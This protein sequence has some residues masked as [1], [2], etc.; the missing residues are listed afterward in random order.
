MSAIDSDSSPMMGSLSEMS[1]MSRSRHSAMSMPMPAAKNAPKTFRGRPESLGQFMRQY[2][3]LALLHELSEREKCEAVVDYCSTRVKETIEGL[4][5][6]Q[7]GHWDELKADIERVFDVESVVKKFNL[8]HLV[9]LCRRFSSG[10]EGAMKSMKQ[11][12]FYVQSFIRIAGSLQA[13]ERISDDDFATY[14]WMG[15]PPAFREKLETRIRNKLPDHDISRPF[16]VDVIQASAEELLHRDRFD[17]QRV[18]W[19]P[20][21]DD[22]DESDDES[23]YYDDSDDED[24]QMRFNKSFKKQEKTGHSKGRISPEL[25]PGLLRLPPKTKETSIMRSSP[26]RSKT[27]PAQDDDVSSLIE[28]MNKLSVTDKAYGLLYYRAKRI[29][30]GVVGCVPPPRL[31]VDVPTRPPQENAYRTETAYRPENSF[32]SDNAYRSNVAYA[33][34]RRR[35]PTSDRYSDHFSGCYG[36]GQRGHNF[37][38]C[39]RIL[40]M[41]ESGVIQR[42]PQGVL[43]TSDGQR[44]YRDSDE[45]FIQALEKIPMKS[46]FI[47]LEEDFTEDSEP[48]SSAVWAAQFTPR[49]PA[50]KPS[51]RPVF[52][53]VQMP[54]RPRPPFQKPAQSRGSTHPTPVDAIPSRFD[55]TKDDIVMEDIAMRPPP[56]K[57]NPLPS[58]ETHDKG[59][60]APRAAARHSALSDK[61]SPARVIEQALDTPVTLTIGQLLG[62]SRELTQNLAELLRFKKPVES[63]AITTNSVPAR[64]TAPLLRLNMMCNGTAVSFVIDSGS[65]VNLLSQDI[66]HKIGLPVD[67]RPSVAIKDANGGLGRAVGMIPN[68]TVSCGHIQTRTNFFIAKGIPFD[69]LLGRPWQSD[70]LVSIKEDLKGTFLEFPNADGKTISKVL[71]NQRISPPLREDDSDVESDLGYVMSALLADEHQGESR[72]RSLPGL[73]LAEISMDT[74]HQDISTKHI[75]KKPRLDDPLLMVTC[76]EKPVIA[77]VDAASPISLISREVWDMAKSPGR[78]MNGEVIDSKHGLTHELLAKITDLP[79]IVDIEGQGVTTVTDAFVTTD[80]SVPLLLGSPWLEHNFLRTSLQ[81]DTFRVTQEKIGQIGTEPSRL[82]VTGQTASMAHLRLVDQPFIA[83]LDQTQLLNTMGRRAQQELGLTMF[84]RTESTAGYQILGVVEGLSFFYGH[85]AMCSVPATF[86]ILDSYDSPITL[87]KPWFTDNHIHAPKHR[88]SEYI[89]LPPDL[90]LPPPHSPVPTEIV[91]TSSIQISESGRE[92]SQGPRMVTVKQEEDAEEGDSEPDD[93][94]GDSSDCCSSCD[95]ERRLLRQRPRR[96]SRRRSTPGPIKIRVRCN[97]ESRETV[98][99]PKG[100]SNIMSKAVWKQV[101]CPLTS[102]PIRTLWTGPT[103]CYDVFGIAK[104]VVIS[105][106]F[107]RRDVF[108]TF[109]VVEQDTPG[110]S[111]GGQWLM[112][113]DITLPPNPSQEQV[114]LVLSHDPARFVGKTRE[115]APSP[116]LTRR[117]SGTSEVSQE[118]TPMDTAPGSP[119]TEECTPLETCSHPPVTV[120]YPDHERILDFYSRDLRHVRESATMLRMSMIKGKPKGKIS[121]SAM[122]G[123]DVGSTSVAGIFGKKY[124]LPECTMQSSANDWEWIGPAIVQLFPP[125]D[126]LDR[127]ARHVANLRRRASEPVPPKVFMSSAVPQSPRASDHSIPCPPVEVRYPRYLP[128]LHRPAFTRISTRRPMMTLPG[129]ICGRVIPF[130][131]DTASEVNILHKDVWKYAT[132]FHPETA[133]R[134][135]PISELTEVPAICDYGGR[136]H[137]AIGIAY[138][139]VVQFGHIATLANFYII[140]GTVPTAVLGQPWHYDHPTSTQSGLLGIWFKLSIP[141]EPRS[142]EAFFP[143]EDPTRKSVVDIPTVYV[144]SVSAQDIDRSP[145]EDITDKL[146]NMSVNL[147]APDPP[148]LEKLSVDFVEL[149]AEHG[150]E[151]AKQ[152]PESILREIAERSALRVH[153]DKPSSPVE[154]SSAEISGKLREDLREFQMWLDI[155]SMDLYMARHL[156]EK[157]QREHPDTEGWFTAESAAPPDSPEDAQGPEKPEE[158]TGE[159]PDIP[160]VH[161]SL[162]TADVDPPDAPEISRQFR[163]MSIETDRTAPEE[164][165]DND[166]PVRIEILD[167]YQP[168]DV[169]DFEIERTHALGLTPNH[170]DF[171]DRIQHML[172]A[173]SGKVNQEDFHGSAVLSVNS[174]APPNETPAASPSRPPPTNHSRPKTQQEMERDMIRFSRWLDIVDANLE[175]I[176]ETVK[177]ARAKIVLMQSLGLPAMF[178]KEHQDPQYAY[179]SFTQALEAVR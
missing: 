84:P 39:P 170:P 75:P 61:V 125:T 176:F 112:S 10:K 165:S 12:K 30:E 120:P 167:Q 127:A 153:S 146:Q 66:A 22:G 166:P 122:E 20:E 29:D 141:T 52:D 159:E 100:V 147:E 121:F 96:R 169:K 68:V 108:T 139:V 50:G 88:E 136:I 9:S 6:Y 152:H 109:F 177:E 160:P 138:G 179:P 54:P 60:V 72:K 173:F 172:L 94:S 70:N 148:V 105:Y 28:Q 64:T 168:V 58:K 8:A 175:E 44:I 124:Y 171:H 155:A 51:S 137:P 90:R 111:L 83:V 110:L 130:I 62:S 27:R 38:R 95:E 37:Y 65:E 161:V 13:H 14:F 79:V 85:Y 132:Q 123:F 34:D 3:R 93:E 119:A 69:G 63:A 17:K 82:L 67:E 32:R 4:R 48:E 36:C 162:V 178:A 133:A 26:P 40:E 104:N 87:G 1:R 91:M 131:F 129:E 92:N 73:D 134:I 103:T 71:I 140:D 5:S 126:S 74:G 102:T 49:P 47:Q 25:P 45:T 59:E 77:V 98:I 35:G 158:D 156:C 53:G 174:S 76:G 107:C 157:I 154:N 128:S 31:D 150:E 24:F 57:R 46:H 118:T 113:Q 142:Y 18:I 16:P 11:W 151:L 55:P 2:E 23:D 117:V 144:H 97:G 163:E 19:D 78:I 7:L 43:L 81:G 99:D 143:A 21:Y 114:E 33:D 15:I 145:E 116:P 135:T 101:D 42:S 86:Y 89:S 164:E 149:V 41:I 56:A 80:D 106:G 115:N